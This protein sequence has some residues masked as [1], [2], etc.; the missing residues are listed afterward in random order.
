V[1]VGSPPTVRRRQLGRELRRLREEANLHLDQLAER[2]RCSPSRISRIETARIRIAP[3]TVHEILDVLEIRDDRRVRRVGLAR[4]ADEPGWWQQFSDALTYEYSTY[5]AME[6]EA[7]ALRAFEPS[8][9]H[10]LLQTEE[11]AQRV[12]ANEPVGVGDAESKLAARMA[13]QKALS[14]PDP[15]RLDVVLDEAAVRRVVGGP[16]VMERQLSH[17]IS[18][19]RQPNIGVQVLPFDAGASA[20]ATGPFAI[21]DFP[22]PGEAPVVYMENLGGDVYVERPAEVHSVTVVFRRLCKDALD[23][24]NSR[25]LL[26]RIRVSLA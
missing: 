18:L 23:P 13:R 11:Y 4:E 22:D 26:D 24:D 19:S 3:G 12:I 21:V 25:L 20:C 10:G 15:L 7:S 9:V 6:A 1:A 5:I 8:I 14:R 16:A 17:L 2:L